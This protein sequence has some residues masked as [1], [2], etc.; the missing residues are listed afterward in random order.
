MDLSRTFD[1]LKIKLAD[2]I[3]GDITE[4][5]MRDF[6]ES[7]FQY[8]GLRLSPQEFAI[9]PGQVIGTS[10][11]CLNQFP[12]ATVS[13]SDVEPNPTDS[14][15][16]I[17]RA[18]VYLINISLS[19]T[20]TANSEWRGSLFKNEIDMELCT[21]KEMLLP[22]IEGNAGG[23]DPLVIEADDVLEYRVQ[24]SM[25]NTTFLLEAGQFNVFRIG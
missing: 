3:T 10:F 1:Q 8:G 25:I 11:I 7:I 5:V 4:Q 12:T 14:T 24:S 2:N 23:F 22:F 21:F 20:G 6:V 9:N 16:K 13:S 19:F 15:I 18:G 17:L